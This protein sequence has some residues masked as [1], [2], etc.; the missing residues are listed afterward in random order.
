MHSNYT[1][2]HSMNLDQIVCT[3]RQLNV[4]LMRNYNGKIGLNTTANKFYSINNLIALERLELKF[5]HFKK[6][7]KAQFLKYGNT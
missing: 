7:A 1:F 5:P 3:S 2:E 4:Q 6:T